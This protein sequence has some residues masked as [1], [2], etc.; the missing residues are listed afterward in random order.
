MGKLLRFPTQE[1]YDIDKAFE[2]VIESG[3]EAD[4]PARLS[5]IMNHMLDA[6]TYKAGYS[7]GKTKKTSSVIPWK[8]SQSLSF[9]R[10]SL[11]YF[12]RFNYEKD[13]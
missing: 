8:R 3:K 6:Q 1:R 4:I 2:K 13:L 7:C 12:L 5:E 10:S 11:M 9:A